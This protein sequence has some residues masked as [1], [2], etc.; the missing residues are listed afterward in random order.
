[1]L[2]RRFTIVCLITTLFGMLFAVLVAESAR[3]GDRRE[4]GPIVCAIDSLPC[5][6]R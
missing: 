4:V 6:T 1:M 2:A 3:T 5:Q